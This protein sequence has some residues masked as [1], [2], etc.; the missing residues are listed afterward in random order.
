MYTNIYIFMLVVYNVCRAQQSNVVHMSQLSV[1]SLMYSI[2]NVQASLTSRSL[3]LFPRVGG[4]G[5][6]ASHQ[7]S[8]MQT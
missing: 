7:Q 5:A 1:F 4:G 3:L 2:D 6:G 8:Q